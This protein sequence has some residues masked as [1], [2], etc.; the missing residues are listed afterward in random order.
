MS[1][2]RTI[3]LPINLSEEEKDFVKE[4]QKNTKFYGS[5]FL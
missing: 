4:L 5:L 1:N 2:I 3:K